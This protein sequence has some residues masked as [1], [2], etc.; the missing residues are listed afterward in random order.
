VGPHG[1]DP[2]VAFEPRLD[3]G[4]QRQPVSGPCAIAAATARLSATIGP[5]ATPSSS[6]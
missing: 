6:P 2:V 4:E 3:L 5:G 1:V